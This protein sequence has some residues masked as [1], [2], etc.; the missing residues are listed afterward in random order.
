MTTAVI[1]A[2]FTPVVA[3]TADGVEFLPAT[4]GYFVVGQYYIS[5]RAL[6]LSALSSF[7]EKKNQTIGPQTATARA[8]TADNF[9][10]NHKLHEGHL[11]ILYVILQ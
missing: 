6:M 1:C 8:Q 5:S 10:S 3:G 4:N 2:S 7:H 11:F 9:V